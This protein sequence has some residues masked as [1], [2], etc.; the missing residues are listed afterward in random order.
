MEVVIHNLCMHGLNITGLNPKPYITTVG[1]LKTHSTQTRTV[2]CL[3]VRGIR[4]GGYW[5][6]PK[7]AVSDGAEPISGCLWDLANHWVNTS[8]RGLHP[9]SWYRHGIFEE[10]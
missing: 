9:H 1:Q 6:L 5:K 2:K 4:L 3:P 8:P 7:T 10:T